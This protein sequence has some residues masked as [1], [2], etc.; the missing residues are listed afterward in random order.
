MSLTAVDVI[1][2][3]CLIVCL[4]VLWCA[5][6]GVARWAP[7]RRRRAREAEDRY[8]RILAMVEVRAEE[9]MW[10]EYWCRCLETIC[11]G[12]MSRQPGGAARAARDMT[13]MRESARAA[14]DRRI[15]DIRQMED[16]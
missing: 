6:G 9:R 3:A 11:E 4:L 2:A 13:R 5:V 15:S 7:A 12:L 1:A 16:A 14:F 10:G 8:C